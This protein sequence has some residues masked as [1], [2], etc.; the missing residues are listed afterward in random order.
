VNETLARHFWP[1]QD[2]VGRRVTLGPAG[3]NLLTV[4]GVAADIRHNGLAEEVEPE[5]YLPF[6]QS[7]QSGMNLAIRTRSDPTSVLNAVRAQVAASDPEQP[8]YDVST[9]EQRLADSV[10]P[11]RFNM[12]LLGAFALLALML[13]GVGIY[14]VMSYSVVQR[15]HEIG[16]RMALG[17]L[18][19]DV[20][21][22]VVGQGMKLALVAAAVGLA[23]AL[24]LTRVIA[25]LLYGVGPADFATFAAVSLLL[26]LVAFLATYLP[27][28]RA[29]KVDPSVALRY[30]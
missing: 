8:V 6:L 20:L 19:G 16:V 21:R 11:R 29:T 15:T 1:N 7:P 3:P 5:L 4:A 25:S 28:R 18:G 24:A 12:L 17:A 10:A 9:M 13:A 22:M 30:E 26:L 14:G 23:A 2:P 27:A